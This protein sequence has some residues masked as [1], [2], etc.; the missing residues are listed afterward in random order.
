MF[1]AYVLT[2]WI[3]FFIE[4]LIVKNDLIFQI[5]HIF[6]VGYG[7]MRN[8]RTLL[9]FLMIS[10]DFCSVFFCRVNHT[11]TALKLLPVSGGYLQQMFFCENAVYFIN[12]VTYLSW[13]FDLRFV[14][15]ITCNQLIFCNVIYI[16]K[17]TNNRCWLPWPWLVLHSAGC[18]MWPLADARPPRLWLYNKKKIYTHT[19]SGV[20]VPQNAPYVIYTDDQGQV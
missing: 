19:V 17:Y 7:N 3:I 10:N 1:H 4:I 9:I 14:F 11:N 8:S 5:S 20:P 6:G 15:S 12:A 18:C 2:V 13:L 16:K